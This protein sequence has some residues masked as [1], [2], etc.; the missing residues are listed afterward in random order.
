MQLW[1]TIV[2]QCHLLRTVSCGMFLWLVLAGLWNLLCFFQLIP[3]CLS[4]CFTQS[5]ITTA[6]PQNGSNTILDRSLRRCAFRLHRIWTALRPDPRNCSHNDSSHRNT[7]TE[8]RKARLQGTTEV[9]VTL[10]WMRS[11]QTS[12]II[13]VWHIVHSESCCVRTMIQSNETNWSAAGLCDEIKLT[14]EKLGFPQFSYCFGVFSLKED[15][16]P[17]VGKAVRARI[18]WGRTRC[19]P[20]RPGGWGGPS[21]LCSVWEYIAKTWDPSSGRDWHVA[22][23]P[24]R[25]G[26]GGGGGAPPRRAGRPAPPPASVCPGPDALEDLISKLLDPDGCQDEQRLGLCFGGAWSCKPVSNGLGSPGLNFRSLPEGFWAAVL[27]DDGSLESFPKSHH[28][29]RFN[30]NC[31][32]VWPR[33]SALKVVVFCSLERRLTAGSQGRN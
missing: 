14:F 12:V 26:G 4:L 25:G 8:G 27:M 19:G 7:H 31:K 24:A 2:R 6:A 17:K 21:G 33:E 1:V 23:R 28:S 30:F 11:K 3:E 22:G 13:H 32:F 29:I 5:G 15:D 10:G 16:R 18:H 20:P 9:T